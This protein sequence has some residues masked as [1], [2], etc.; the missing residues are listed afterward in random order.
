MERKK[1]HSLY[2]LVTYYYIYQILKTP[3]KLSELIHK[4]SKVA[5]FISTQKWLDYSTLVSYYQNVKLRKQLKKK[6]RKQC[7]TY[8]AG[9][10]PWSWR[11]LPQGKA[12]LSH[13]RYAGLCDFSKCGKLDCIICRS[14]GLHWCFPVKEKKENN[15]ITIASKRIKYTELK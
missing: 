11:W 10:I 15:P 3:L 4:V 8:L 5:R 12:H 9:E 6:K 7:H 13:S 2:L 14:G 1:Q